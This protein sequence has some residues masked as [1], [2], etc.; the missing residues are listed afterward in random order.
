MSLVRQIAFLKSVKRSFLIFK[1]NFNDFLRI[2]WIK[3]LYFN[4]KMFKF[5][6]AVK[7]PVLFYGKVRFDSLRG[8]IIINAPII[9]GMVKFGYNIEII[10]KATGISELKIDGTFII[11][12][13]FCTGVDY[14]LII[15][16]GGI[17]E[18]GENSHLG[19]KIKIIVTKKVTLGKYFRLS[20][21]S[22]IFDST[23]H[24]MLD[25]EANEV[26]RFDGEILINDYC[27]VGNR[28][29][30]L[31]NTI[32]PKYTT[33]ASNS[34]L[35]KDYTREVPEKSLIGGMPAILIKKN[36][37][38]IYDADKEAMISD[39]FYANPEEFIFKASPDY[40]L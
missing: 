37:S 16:R 12:G 5:Q 22:Q 31:K 21:E 39:F 6:T 34:I 10:R 19:S 20:F 25:T 7:L 28:T 13:K 32:T 8:K 2:K 18:I 40:L 15:Q 1:R 23:F 11:N 29:S 4:F 3:T 17:L 33:I 38:R 30:I 24:Y 14:A 26:K 27:W 36:I 9:R 35:N